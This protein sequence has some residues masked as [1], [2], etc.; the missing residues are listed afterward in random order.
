MKTLGINVDVNKIA[1]G[2]HGMFDE[3]ERTVLAFGMLPK[4]KM[5]ILEKMLGEKFDKIVE[6][7]SQ[8]IYGMSFQEAEDLLCDLMP[9]LSLKPIVEK[10]KKKF[11]RETM[12]KICIA[13][14]QQAD[15]L[16]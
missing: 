3:E 13:I 7:Q 8:K 4:T 10:N 12:H 2:I 1:F 11:I 9:E 15:M 14:Y 5:D 6:E 16:V